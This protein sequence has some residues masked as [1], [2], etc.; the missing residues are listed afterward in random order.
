MFL[1]RASRAV[2]LPCGPA[3]RGRWALSGEAAPGT[4]WVGAGVAAQYPRAPHAPLPHTRRLVSG[5]SALLPGAR[6]T[7]ARR[8]ARAGVAGTACRGSGEQ[9]LLERAPPRVLQ[10]LRGEEQAPWLQPGQGSAAPG[11]GGLASLSVVRRA[12]PGGRGGPGPHLASI[13]ACASWPFCKTGNDL[14]PP[15]TDG[16]VGTFWPALSSARSL[17][18]LGPL[19][20]A[21]C[22]AATA[23]LREP[24]A[25]CRPVQWGGRVLWPDAQ[26]E[27]GAGKEAKR[28]KRCP[29]H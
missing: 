21:T 24:S 29:G 20:R 6:A 26:Q 5:W 28:G 15:W 4:G 13:A 23:G 1:L 8:L 2:G 9:G 22:G 25:L 27:P 7:P 12:C 16:V 11:E 17:C 19:Y 3:P 14:G 10:G 18:A